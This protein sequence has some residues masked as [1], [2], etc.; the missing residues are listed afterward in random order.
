VFAVLA[1]AIAGGLLPAVLTA[2]LAGVALNLVFLQ[3]YGTL[4]VRAVE[5]G[6]GLVAFVV[7]ALVVGVLVSAINEGR[8]RLTRRNVERAELAAERERLLQEARRARELTRIDDQRTVLLRSVSHDLRTPLSAIRAIAG[9]LRDG[10]A[11][12]E[13]TRRELLGIV[14]DEA[15]RLD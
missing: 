3:P 14:V 8:L 6:I 13:D 10:V 2:I 7:V 5:D 1:A 11:Y 4:K 12:D 15:D 9:D